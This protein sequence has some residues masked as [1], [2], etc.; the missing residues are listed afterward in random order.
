MPISRRALIHRVAL[1]TMAIGVHR[2][3]AEEKWPD[4]TVN[5][6]VPRAP[7]GGTDILIRILSPGLQ[8]RLG[9]PFVVENKPDTVA[10]AGANYV[11]RSKPDG[12]VFF[13]S[14]NAFYQNPAILKSLPYDT[15][16]DFSGV[17]ML[18][19]APVVLVVN[20]ELPI[21]SVSDLIKSAKEK[22][23]TLSFGSGGIG[24]STHIGGIQFALAAG[25]DIIHVPYR[26]S[27]PAL[28]DLLGGH[29]TMQFGGISSAKGQIEVGKLRALATTGASRDP[30]LPD[31]PTF[32]ELGLKGVDITS[33]WGVH[34]PA[35]T[36]IEIRSRLR[37]V[38]VDVMKTPD[39]SKR[40]AD[41]GY[42]RIG[43]S[44]DE[45]D[46]ETKKLIAQWIDLSHRVKLSD[47]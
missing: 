12:Y 39:V 38:L 9:Q 34:A 18:A 1:A 10:V 23:G 35:G 5:M 45:L 40:M 22:P 15:V 32:A 42:N 43:N 46:A 41:L 19:D 2:A 8:D 37:D 33:I 28:N 4:R 11:A 21:Q 30:G 20:A 44:P 24:T 26:S 6:I 16:K 17:T 31:V 7:G 27:G 14:D 3:S 47:D 25:V 36:P 13:A 29:L